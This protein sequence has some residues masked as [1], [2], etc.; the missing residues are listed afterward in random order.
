MT[1]EVA[2]F[3]SML[4]TEL[5]YFTCSV[6]RMNTFGLNHVLFALWNPMLWYPAGGEWWVLLNHGLVDSPG[7]YDW[8][9][10]MAQMEVSLSSEGENFT[11]EQFLERVSVCIGMSGH[12]SEFILMGSSDSTF[13]LHYSRIP[14]LRIAFNPWTFLQNRASQ[15]LDF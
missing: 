10:L 8:P 6:Y 14:S 4:Y 9:W 7:L 13:W 12:M 2:K 1:C 5:W 3:L 11:Q 15:I